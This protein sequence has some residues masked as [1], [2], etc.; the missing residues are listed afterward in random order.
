MR[1]SLAAVVETPNDVMAHIRAAYI[2]DRLG[3]NK[4]AIKNYDA[5]WNLGIPKRMRCEFF[6]GYG[7]TL[8]NVGRFSD[9]VK[10]L[11]IASKE[12]PRNRAIRVFLAFSLY[13]SKR[14]QEAMTTLLDVVIAL[15]SHAIDLKQY[16]R[17][18]KYYRNDL[19][20]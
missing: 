5:A 4:Q 10:I 16:N 8:R 11:T 12:F 18:I 17:A 3:R 1:N 20:R 2:C 9:S 7:S 19:T 13:S 15:D 14:Y 6:I